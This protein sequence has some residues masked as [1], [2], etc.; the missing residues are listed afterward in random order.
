M[1]DVY[2]SVGGGYA[3]SA[4]NN[5]GRVIDAPFATVGGGIENDAM[6]TNATIGGGEQNT[7]PG[8]SATVS[9]GRNNTA[10]A[11]F[12]SVNGGG[13]NVAAGFISIYREA[14]STV[15]AAIAPRCESTAACPPPLAA[16]S[17]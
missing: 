4:G 5:T 13:D 10:Y 16:A 9:G 1:S 7:V 11:G 17:G 14:A 15:P 6:A 12:A 3:N 8:P 2:G